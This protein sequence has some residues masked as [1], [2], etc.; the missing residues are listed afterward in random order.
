M[1]LSRIEVCSVYFWSTRR[2]KSVF[3]LVSHKPDV[4]TSLLFSEAFFINAVAILMSEILQ[5]V[6]CF[7]AIKPAMTT[8]TDS[9]NVVAECAIFAFVFVQ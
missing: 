5:Y 3:Q 4:V 7:D 1:F 9:V 8:A 2:L 6:I